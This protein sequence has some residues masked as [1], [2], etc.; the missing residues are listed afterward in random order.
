MTER[1][2]NWK[3]NLGKEAR[4]RE[5]ERADLL[6]RLDETRIKIKGCCLDFVSY[7]KIKLE[8]REIVAKLATL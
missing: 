7:D 3:E 2:H 1:R 6:A 5:R 8:Q 4:E